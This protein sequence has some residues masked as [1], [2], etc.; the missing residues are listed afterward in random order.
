MREV[1][2]RPCVF[3]SDLPGDNGRNATHTTVTCQY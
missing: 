2:D 1:I 3:H